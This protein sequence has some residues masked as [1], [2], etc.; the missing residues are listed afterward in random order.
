V[1][2]RINKERKNTRRKKERTKSKQKIKLE[3]AETHNGGSLKRRTL[4]LEHLPTA[5]C[6]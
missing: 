4:N 2:E 1:R 6:M 3:S 5:L